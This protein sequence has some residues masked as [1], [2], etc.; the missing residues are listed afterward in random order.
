MPKK[1]GFYILVILYLVSV[2]SL[3]LLTYNYHEDHHT[4]LTHRVVAFSANVVLVTLIFAAIVLYINNRR[5]KQANKT[6]YQLHLDNVDYRKHEK[7]QRELYEKVIDEL[8]QE[9][10]FLRSNEQQRYKNSSLDDH[11]RQDILSKI[12]NVM[13]YSDKIFDNDFDLNTLAD[14]VG[15]N[16][17][18]VSQVINQ[19]FNKNFSAYLSDYRV[20]EACR[21]LNDHEHYDNNTI[22]AVAESVGF[23]SRS[24]FILCFKRVTGMTPSD[25]QKQAKNN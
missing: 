2:G 22:E 20:Q 25:Y 3:I 16:Y 19:E 7:Q 9:I 17:K 15:T 21:R 23:K 11:N 5:L 13:E 8:K 18:Y 1:F 14:M 12:I 4:D 24:N 6:L 10:D